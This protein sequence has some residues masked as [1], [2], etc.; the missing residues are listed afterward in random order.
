VTVHVA[1]RELR[2]FDEGGLIKTVPRR[3]Q[4]EVTRFKAHQQH[5]PHGN[6]G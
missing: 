3:Q 6:N 4:Q 2:I 5:T 1:E